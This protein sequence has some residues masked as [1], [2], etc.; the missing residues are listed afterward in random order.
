MRRLFSKHKSPFVSTYLLILSNQRVTTLKF[1]GYL[2]RKIVSSKI[3]SIDFIV[4][5]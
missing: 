2:Y 5:E 1:E 3:L 4:I